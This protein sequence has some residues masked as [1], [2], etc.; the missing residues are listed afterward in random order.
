MRLGTDD[1]RYS[2]LPP[3]GGERRCSVCA[4]AKDAAARSSVC[5]VYSLQQNPHCAPLAEAHVFFLTP[6][7]MPVFEGTLFPRCFVSLPRCSQGN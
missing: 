5:P 2:D 6:C 3:L 7:V 1:I 4:T